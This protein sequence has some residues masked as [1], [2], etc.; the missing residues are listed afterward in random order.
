MYLRGYYGY[1]CFSKITLKFLCFNNSCY[2]LLCLPLDF[3]FKYLIFP[4]TKMK[5]NQYIATIF[6]NYLSTTKKSRIL[7]NRFP[8]SVASAKIDVVP[9]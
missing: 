9:I 3:V 8:T 6:T 5:N 4:E 1:C 2:N 7:R